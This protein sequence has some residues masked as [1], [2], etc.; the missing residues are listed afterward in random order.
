ML[1]VYLIL[2]AVLIVLLGL[3]LTMG[4][5]RD[6]PWP[7]AAWFFFLVFIGTWFLGGWLAP[8]DATPWGARWMLGGIIAGGMALLFALA[9]TLLQWSLAG[10]QATQQQRIAVSVSVYTFL[11]TGFVSILL[12][13]I[14]QHFIRAL[15]SIS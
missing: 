12:A 9:V 8:F 11:W 13:M 4:R 3:G 6:G 2:L 1:V 14:A 15:Q 5:L 7:A 10:G